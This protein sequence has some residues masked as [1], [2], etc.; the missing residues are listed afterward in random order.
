MKYLLTLFLC[1]TLAALPLPGR[2]QDDADK[3]VLT[4]LIQ[5]QLSGA[6]RTVDIEGFRGALS[7]E[8]TLERLTI[9]DDDGVWLELTGAVFSWNRSALLRGRL[10]VQELSA[11][12]ITLTR[13]PKS[14]DSG[15]AEAS[16][17]AI[18][19][20]PVA[21]DIGRVAIDTLTIGAAVLGEEAR[22]SFDGKALLDGNHLATDLGLQRLD[23]AG[24]IIAQID[25]QPDANQLVL[26]VRAEEPENGIVARMLDLPGRPA[27]ELAVDGDGP[28]DDFTA[29]FRLASDGQERLAGTVTL[30]GSEDGA[31][32]FAA[33]LGGDLTAI[34]LPQAREFL[35][36]DVRL[37]AQGARTADGALALD[38]LQLNA[39]AVSLSGS[40][41][42]TPDGRPARFDIQGEI[43]AGDGTPVTLPFGTGL[44]LRQATITAGFDAAQGPDVTA[45]INMTDYAQPDLTIGTGAVN[46]TGTIATTG[47]PAV[48]LDLRA[49]LDALG[50]A[51][52]ALQAAAGTRVSATTRVTWQQG[53]D[54]VIDG[55]D[56]QGTDYN[57][58]LNAVL[59]TGGRTSILIADGRAALA[60]LS[61]L[62][63]LAGADLSGQADLAVEVSADLLGGSI[64]LSASGATT[65]L[66][67]GIAQLDP[68]IGG[69][70]T[71]ELAASRGPQGIVLD[72]FALAN[73][74]VEITA[75]GQL[76]NDS[77]RIDY[78]A[79]LANSGAFTGA[80]GGPLEI[81][82]AVQRAGDRFDVT[83]YGGGQDLATGIAQVDALLAGETD[84]SLR[85]ALTDRIM[86]ED[87]RIATP[88][89]S[90]TATGELTAGARDVTVTGQL[91]DSGSVT[92]QAGGP[93]DLTIRAVQAGADY[94]V[95][96]TGTGRDL[97][98]GI[99]QA[100]ALLRGQTD[101]NVTLRM[102]RQMLLRDARLTN[103]A[104]TLT[105]AGELTAGAR[106]L[107][108]TLRLNDSGLPLGAAG[109]P[110]TANLRA[111]QDGTAYDLTLDGTGTDIGT[112][113]ALVDDILRGA[114]SFDAAGRFDQGRLRLDRANVD[115]QSF[116]ASAS[117]MI[118]AGAT[119]VDFNARLASLAQ[120]VP[121]APAGP[122]SAGGSV[123]QDESGALALNIAAEGPGGTVA[124]V[125]GLVG[126]AGGAVDL[127]ITGNGPL[128]LANPYIAPQSVTGT[129]RFDL[130]LAGQPGLS[131][132]SGQVT[133]SG[134]RASLPAAA[135]AIENINGTL[136]LAAGQAQIDLAANV[137][138]GTLTI[139]G[140]VTL[141]GAYPAELIAR[142]A[143]VPVERPG[144]LSTRANGEVR[145][146]GGLTGGGMISG[147]IGLSDT[148]LRIPS[149]GFG[150]VE[151]IPEMRHVNE[152]AASR[153]TRTRAGLT[154]GG[155]TGAGGG[156]SRPLGLNLRI[157]ADNAMFL[158]GR[159]IDA[160]LRGGLTLEGTTSD[161]RPVGRFDLVRG[162]I[163]VLTKR[164][165]LTEGSVRLAGGFDP[166]VRLVA[167]SQAGEYVVQIVIEG[168]AAAPEVVF[169]SR[170][171][172]PE[173]EVLSQL[174]FERDIAS[175]SPL[176]AARLALA[177]AELTGGGSGG[178]VGKIR[179]GAGLD[180]LDVT[181][182]K[183]GETALSAGKYVSENIYTEVEATSAGKTSVSI[184]LDVTRNLTAKGKLGSDGDSSIGLF[185]EK[186]Y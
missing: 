27:L 82:G 128:A 87:A 62:A 15:G 85:V 170:P 54:V 103:P 166:I 99:A 137:N 59:S 8:A 81:T 39:A 17:F 150:G 89:L 155:G 36:D 183:E 84:L 42:T 182:T 126:M 83:A 115:G 66:A 25:L 65:D 86:L 47:T 80:D 142:L 111:V 122:L 125:A 49:V 18:P 76:G 119:T 164:L 73:S 180:D 181:Q 50:F 169:T 21:I 138:G 11:R 9:A 24:R 44:T 127:D 37:V 124:Q 20:L 67:L 58:Q 147:R 4:R 186:D 96:V 132:L 162:R 107:R 123:R 163:D 106:D 77:G 57:A 130:S 168:P 74:Q 185:F 116:D 10:E 23:R 139:N 154:D 69:D 148:E 146:S 14:E 16:G 173:D 165:I 174:F 91:Y 178:V 108:A 129:A 118:A 41:A 60:D 72:T 171:D 90:V 98:T 31:Q 45:A 135:L 93:L 51:D 136:A 175:L 5:D 141:S 32:S 145:V 40:L 88:A 149:G 78:A 172:L 3:G 55:L 131:A 71:L 2:A 53:G 176:Q 1:L 100:D 110:V 52:P 179:D 63:P 101:L 134:A 161:I 22:F 117:G 184:N 158:R 120:V 114:T 26:E 75:S 34:L 92:G 159:G 140:P 48:D 35:G 133:V 64:A 121:Q 144:L 30:T 167:E 13:L 104:L 102:G 38:T 156:G 61:R 113:Q 12:T 105:A 7:S 33:D 43:A 19:D 94:D 112:G 153:A 157:E 70:A 68:V 151:A 6:G 46:L 152:D 28:L 79:L 29:N 97:A 177:I 143:N 160:E 109:G 56:L 95:T